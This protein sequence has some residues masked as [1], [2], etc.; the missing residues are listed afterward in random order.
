MAK[1]DL[2]IG[3]IGEFGFIASIKDDCHYS[4]EKLIRGIGDDCAVIGPYNGNVFLITTDM[5]VEDIH[6]ISGKIHPEELGQKVMAVNLSDIAAMGGTPLHVFISLA[7]PISMEVSIIHSIYDGMKAMCRDYGVNILGGDT[8]SSP[9]KI[10]INVCMIGEAPENEVLYRK[11]AKPGDIIYV[12]GTLGDSAAGLKII[13]EK[14]NAPVKTASILIGAHNRPVPFLKAGRI[15]A[16][17]KLAGAMIDISDGLI[18]DLRHVCKASN[19]GARLLFSGIP[20]STEV[21]SMAR[22]NDLDP[23]ELALYG[24]EDYRLLVIIPERNAE[25]FEGLFTNGEPC[26]IYRVGEITEIG[27]IGMVMEN[28]NEKILKIGGYDHFNANSF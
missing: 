26:H 5:L 18:S 13:R 4:P 27:G 15:I 23:Y 2:R 14:V 20:L 9:E 12:T 17:S 1:K 3:D 10:S 25:D 19:V 7:V 11:G 21:I 8:C 6:F 24:G 28:G 16:R 22:S